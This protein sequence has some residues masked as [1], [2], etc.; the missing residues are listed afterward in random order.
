MAAKVFL[1][2]EEFWTAISDPV[3]ANNY[4]SY[5]PCC[6][7]WVSR[8]K[9]VCRDS[10][11]QKIS[12]GAALT[13][14]GFSFSDS[15]KY[16]Q[17]HMT[18]HQWGLPIHFNAPCSAQVPQPALNEALQNTPK[19]VLTEPHLSSHSLAPAP[20]VHK[21]S[22]PLPTQD[23][24]PPFQMPQLAIQPAFPFQDQPQSPSHKNTD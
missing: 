17:A 7:V 12:W 23:L 20:R 8:T 19:P 2:F 13:S 24:Q 10:H 21:N 4:P 5:H 6:K 18:E 9:K 22:M 14:Q 3:K 15:K 16:L 1:A 11:T